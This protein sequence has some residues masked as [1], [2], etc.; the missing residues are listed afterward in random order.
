LTEAATARRYPV[1]RKLRDRPTDTSGEPKK[2]DTDASD[3]YRAHGA[4]VISTRFN[5]TIKA[6]IWADGEIVVSNSKGEEIYKL[7][8]LK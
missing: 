2:P 8:E 6:R 3:E 5:G 1:V 4:D 7:P